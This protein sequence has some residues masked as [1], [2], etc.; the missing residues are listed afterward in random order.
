MGRL[1]GTAAVA[2][3]PGQVPGA[4]AERDQIARAD[5]PA[6]SGQQ[7]GERVR[8]GRVVQHAQRGHHVLHLGD[9]QQTAEADY[10]ARDGPRL[11]SPAQ[12][13]EL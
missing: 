4:A 6:R 11:Q 2:G 7:P 10:L 12:L 1:I 9:G 8:R 13:R 3:A 5:P